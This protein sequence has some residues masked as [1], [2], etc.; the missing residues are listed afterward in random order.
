M[1]FKVH[2]SL[3]PM[4]GR[5]ATSTTRSHTKSRPDTTNRGSRVRAL[6][7]SRVSYFFG[8]LLPNERERR[9]SATDLLSGE[10]DGKLSAS[11]PDGYFK[12]EKYA[13]TGFCLDE[14]SPT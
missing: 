11:Q 1:L 12:H 9:R 5:P 2:P 6:K 13:I 10:S 4:A 8:L 14:M 7:S 3:R